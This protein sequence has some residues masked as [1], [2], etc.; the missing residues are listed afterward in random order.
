MFDFM[1][2]EL[3][4]KWRADTRLMTQVGRLANEFY[5][6]LTPLQ[7][8]ARFGDHALVRHILRKQCQVQ[9]YP[10]FSHPLLP[11]LPAAVALDGCYTE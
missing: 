1:T 10:P 6:S 3:P 5:L 8:A 11:L 4:L 7:L 2:E 9:I